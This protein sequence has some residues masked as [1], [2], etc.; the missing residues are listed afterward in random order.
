MDFRHKAYNLI[1]IIYMMIEWTVV[2]SMAMYFVIK[3]GDLAIDLIKVGYIYT[4]FGLLLFAMVL[5]FTAFIFKSLLGY[6]RRL[7]DE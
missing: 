7:D 2:I 5:I 4:I 3:T 1:K 6:Y